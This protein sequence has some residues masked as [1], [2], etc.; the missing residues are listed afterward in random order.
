LRSVVCCACRASSIS[1]LYSTLSIPVRA[2]AFVPGGS[3]AVLPVGWS[4]LAPVSADC[5]DETALS[6]SP[7]AVINR[8]SAGYAS[9][10]PAASCCAST[11]LPAW[12]RSE[13]FFNTSAGA[14]PLGAGLAVDASAGAYGVVCACTDGR[15][16]STRT[17]PKMRDIESFPIVFLQSMRARV[18]SRLYSQGISLIS[19]R[20]D[21]KAAARQMLFEIGF[22]HITCGIVVI[23]PK[24]RIHHRI[25]D[26]PVCGPIHARNHNLVLDSGLVE[27]NR[28]DHRLLRTGNCPGITVR[29]NRD[30]LTEFVR[31]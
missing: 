8:W 26:F 18:R 24:I 5:E 28:G 29:G 4:A 22:L 7:F 17:N 25:V 12:I 23:R 15:T 30:N 13:S 14:C 27:L 31:H 2:V 19:G 21:H 9:N 6:S 1:E 3:E 11:Y 20:Q 16:V 10:K